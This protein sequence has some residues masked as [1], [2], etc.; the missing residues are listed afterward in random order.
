MPSLKSLD[1]LLA[2]S[3]P[4]IDETVLLDFLTVLP[5]GEFRDPARVIP[6]RWRETDCHERQA[7]FEDVL[8]GFLG[9]DLNR[10]GS[11]LLIVEP[12]LAALLFFGIARTVVP[13]VCGRA[14][15]FSTYESGR[16]ATTL[17]ATVFHAATKEAMDRATA[18]GP[19][20][21]RN[22]FAARAGR[23]ESARPRSAYA[24]RVCEVLV[25][26]GWDALDRMIAAFR[27][28]RPVRPADLDSL[29]EAHKTVGAMFGI[30]SDPAKPSWAPGSPAQ[31]FALRAVAERVGDCAGS[32]EEL[33]AL[34]ESPHAPILLG[35]LAQSAE[36]PD[37][38][39]LL[40]SLL[41]GVTPSHLIAVLRS[42]E[43]P[44]KYRVQALLESVSRHGRWPG[45]LE[46]LIYQHTANRSARLDPVVAEILPDVLGRLPAESLRPLYDRAPATAERVALLLALAP[47]LSSHSKGTA[48]LR[49]IIDVAPEEEFCLLAAAEACPMGEI[50]RADKDGMRQRAGEL[51]RGLPNRPRR[52]SQRLDALIRL[53]TFL[54]ADQAVRVRGWQSVRQVV[55]RLKAA[56]QDRAQAGRWS[57]LASLFGRKSREQAVV[58]AVADA[59]REL[60]VA[61]ASVFP[62]RTDPAQRRD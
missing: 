3:P 37:S 56:H 33:R 34:A 2:G 53:V 5:R 8:E 20:F 23:P 28:A 51:L 11:I 47:R 50:Y 42:P 35:M 6:Q 38:A 46:P 21:V 44:R 4:A 39:P 32:P 13:E 25:N 31:R 12:D 24:A 16:S 17:T 29:A 52:F 1:D 45:E 54:P 55:L 41:A 40:E 49:A 14:I 19:D 27:S 30:P 58:D 9:A 22:T 62:S 61:L 15:S 57:G 48:V 60:A 36:S 10:R 26:E 18:H 59:C 43:I 7:L